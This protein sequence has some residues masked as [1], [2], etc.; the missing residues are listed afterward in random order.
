MAYID[1][2]GDNV[3]IL[4][5]LILGAVIIIAFLLGELVAYELIERRLK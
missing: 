2:E 1:V 5:A 4:W 3:T